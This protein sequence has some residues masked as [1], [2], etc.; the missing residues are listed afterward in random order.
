MDLV[1]E[2]LRWGIGDGKKTKLLSVL[3]SQLKT[4]IPVPEGATVSFLIDEAHGHWDSELVSSVFEEVVAAQIL[5]VPI[6]RLGGDDFASWPHSNFGSYTVKSAYN[7]V[8][9]R[10]FT[11]HRSV[12]GRGSRSD[13]SDEAKNWRRLWTI[14]APGKMK[15]TPSVPVHRAQSEKTFVP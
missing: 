11:L 12:P 13:T 1:K 7:L 9:T 6:S 5:Q 2:G 10:D 15:I 14:K 3:P 4:L 8:R